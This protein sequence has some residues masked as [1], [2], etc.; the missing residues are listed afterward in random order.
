MLLDP[1]IECRRTSDMNMSLEM[2]GLHVTPEASDD[3]A[4]DLNTSNTLHLMVEAVNIIHS[5][6]EMMSPPNNDSNSIGHSYNAPYLNVYNANFHWNEEGQPYSAT[7]EQTVCSP[8]NLLEPDEWKLY[9]YISN[10]TI[11]N[12]EYFVIEDNLTSLPTEHR[13]LIDLLLQRPSVGDK[14]MSEVPK[15][16]VILRVTDTD[17]DKFKQ[18]LAESKNKHNIKQSSSPGSSSYHNTRKTEWINIIENY[19]NQTNDGCVFMYSRHHW[20]TAKTIS[21]NSEKKQFLLS[22]DATCKFSTC[23]C[24]FHAILYDDA[25]LHIKYSGYISHSPSEHRARPIRGSR[26]ESIAEQLSSGLKPDQL[27]LKQLGRLSNDNRLYGNRNIVG[28]SPHVFRKI[29]SETKS[30]LMLDPDLGTS[31]V[32]IQNEQQKE[33]RPEQPLPGYLQDISIL[34]LRLVCFT[35]GGLKLWETVASTV[36]VSWDATGGVVMNRGKKVFYY[37]LTISSI[38]ASGVSKKSRSGPSFPVTSMLSTSHTTMDL[39]HWINTFE[40]AWY[41]IH[42]YGKTFPKP[43]VIHCDGAYVFQ[44]AAI[45]I[46][47]KDENMAEYLQRCWRIVNSTANTNDL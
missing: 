8:Y 14:I 6:K 44:L 10:S 31:L 11:M 19:I 41:K 45:R 43:P 23:K 24:S 25:T 26:R 30:A 35:Y 36:P 46:F 34:P 15:Q 13:S 5:E 20:S 39:V 37:E 3:E 32:K 16:P 22:A 18:Q 40:A 33:I 17:F 42:G 27:R 4:S 29:R 47:T 28:S 7:E 2:P 12:D 9:P 1:T 38:S 21:R